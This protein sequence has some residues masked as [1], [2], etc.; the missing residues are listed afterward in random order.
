[1]MQPTWKPLANSSCRLPLWIEGLPRQRDRPASLL[2]PDC[3]LL[4]ILRIF[5]Q[6]LRDGRKRRPVLRLSLEQTDGRLGTRCAVVDRKL[7][8]V[9]LKTLPQG[10]PG[11]S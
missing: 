1:M 6:F 4:Q 2:S 10:D 11:V 3:G 5:L 8:G 9:P 7:V